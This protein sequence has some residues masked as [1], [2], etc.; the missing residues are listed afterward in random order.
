MLFRSQFQAEQQI[1]EV[2]RSRL[3]VLQE[4]STRLLTAAQATND[5]QALQ[6]AQQFAESIR[7]VQLST[8]RVNTELSEIGGAGLNA[9]KDGLVDLSA[10]G[11]TEGQK[12]SDAMSAMAS[13][14]VASLRRM[15]TEILATKFITSLLRLGGSVGGTGVFEGVPAGQ[16]SPPRFAKGGSVEWRGVSRPGFFRGLP[17]DR[18]LILA[19]TDEFIVRSERTTAPG[20]LPVLEAINAGTLT[21][22]HLPAFAGG[23]LVGGTSVSEIAAPGAG[24]P[25]G[26]GGDAHV[27]VEANGS[28]FE[29]G[30]LRIMA[31]RQGQ[32]VTVRNTAQ[33]RRSM[34]NL[35]G[36]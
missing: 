7:V 16:S 4:L 10:V 18:N 9:L 8:D 36:G 14:V 21:A 12:F 2:E 27:T 3:T 26:R 31:S 17:G 24:G 15:A 28:L 19:K 20:M 33:N 5:P 1:L 25:G 23:G 6:S 11:Q 34:Q 32:R 22:A 30:V 13:S 29:S 35:V